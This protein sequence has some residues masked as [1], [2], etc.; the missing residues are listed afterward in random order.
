MESQYEF[1]PMCAIFSPLLCHS[2]VHTWPAIAAALL[3]DFSSEAWVRALRALLA[4]SLAARLGDGK[5]RSSDVIAQEKAAMLLQK[6]SRIKC[7]AL[8][9]E[10]H[11]PSGLRGGRYFQFVSVGSP[12]IPPSA[13]IVDRT[14]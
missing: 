5:Q 1:G 6:I 14:N 7:V 11:Q 10:S 13:Q 12:R 8:S 2:L 9:R 4:S 3:G